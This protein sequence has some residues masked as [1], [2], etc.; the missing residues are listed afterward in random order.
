MRTAEVPKL[1]N[2]YT[3]KK[4]QGSAM[5]QKLLRL[6]RHRNVYGHWIRESQGSGM[7]QKLL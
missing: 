2:P 7:M 5:M 6:I 3:K 1:N 4:S